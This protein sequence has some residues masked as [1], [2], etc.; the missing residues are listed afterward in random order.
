MANFEVTVIYKV[1]VEAYGNNEALAEAFDTIFC[2]Y[3]KPVEHDIMLLD[4]DK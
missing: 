2:G 4:S 1:Q 3:T